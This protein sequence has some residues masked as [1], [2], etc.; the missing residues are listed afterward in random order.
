VTLIP[1]CRCEDRDGDENRDG[2]VPLP[3][4][5]QARIAAGPFH[6]DEEEQGTQ[7]TGTQLE[8]QGDAHAEPSVVIT[9]LS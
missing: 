8:A 6:K 2:D 3:G 5:H 9:E 1:V 7:V 4:T